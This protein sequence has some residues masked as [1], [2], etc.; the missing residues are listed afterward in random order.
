[1]RTFG[2]SLM[3]LD[4]RQESTRHTEV[5]DA[6]TQHLE[7]GSYSEWDEAARWVAGPQGGSQGVLCG[8]AMGG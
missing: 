4:I 5:I 6:I 8:W 3:R 7:L 1:V 2:L